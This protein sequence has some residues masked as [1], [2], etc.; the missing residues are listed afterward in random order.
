MEHLN[1]GN[2]QIGDEVEIKAGWGKRSGERFIVY[3]SYRIEGRAAL[4]GR[5]LVVSPNPETKRHLDSL[6]YDKRQE[7]WEGHLINLGTP[8]LENE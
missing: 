1:T 8:D 7:W 4:K 5:D 3:K 2:I 6:G